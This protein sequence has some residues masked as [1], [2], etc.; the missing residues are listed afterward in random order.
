MTKIILGVVY[1]LSSPPICGGGD[2][3]GWVRVIGFSGDRIEI[4]QV[5]D[6]LKQVCPACYIYACIL[7]YL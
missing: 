3:E 6:R 5:S 1:S 4:G 2:A 7:L